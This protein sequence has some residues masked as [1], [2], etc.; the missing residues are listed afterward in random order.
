MSD[1]Q[2]TIFDL[3][4][5]ECV[6]HTLHDQLEGGCLDLLCYCVIYVE[7]YATERYERGRGLRNGKSGVT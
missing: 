6:S 1:Q 4:V 7:A 5:I 2:H 3:W